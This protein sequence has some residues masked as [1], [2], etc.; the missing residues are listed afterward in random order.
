MTKQI[1]KRAVTAVAMG[2]MLMAIF[3]LWWTSLIAYG[4]PNVFGFSVQAAF[5]ILVFVLGYESIR[6]FRLAKR[7]PKTTNAADKAQGKHIG[8]AYG[9]IF[10]TEGAAIGAASAIL[11]TTGHDK[12]VIPVIALIVGLHFYPMATLFRRTIDYYLASWVCL[13]ATVGIVLT[14]KTAIPEPKIWSG[15]GFGVA[16]AT[17]IY[18]LY[19]RWYVGKHFRAQNP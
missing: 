18:G 15:V 16:C 9:I 17:V 4:F 10:G 6:T 19:M 1:P 5:T 14:V 11:G 8:K 13:V 2:M 3:T 12:L 7:F